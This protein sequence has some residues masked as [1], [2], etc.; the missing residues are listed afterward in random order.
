MCPLQCK[1]VK[2][3]QDV[4]HFDNDEIRQVGGINGAHHC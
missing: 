3:V 1:N 4:N 2:V